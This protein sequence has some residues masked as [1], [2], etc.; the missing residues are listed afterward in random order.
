MSDF[1]IFSLI[2]GPL[3]LGVLAF[4][5]PGRLRGPAVLLGGLAIIAGGVATALTFMRGGGVDFDVTLGHHGELLAAALE[6]GV[7]L[8]VIG[9][10][11]RIRSGKV[12]AL[13]A[14]QLGLAVVEHL[15]P[16]KVASPAASFHI[17]ALAMILIVITCVIGAIIV[18]YAIGY[19]KV[20]EHHAP[21]SARRTGTFFLFLVGFLGAMNGLVMANEFRWLSVFWEAT[22]LCSFMLIGHDGTR[23]ARRNAHRALLI[24]TF[25]GAVLMGGA[26]LAGLAGNVNALSG[27]T[28]GTGGAAVALVCLAMF[29]VAACTK[30]AQMP[31]Q[32]WLLG[33]MVAPTPVSAL[34]HSATMVNAG[35]YI[36]LR[37]CPSFAGSPM[38]TIIALAGAFTFALTSALAAT[39]SN[40]KKVLAYSTIA[41][42]GLIVTCAG[43]N[44]PLAYAAGLMVLCFH[45]ASKGLL[46]LCIGSIEQEIGS[47]DIE[48]M[49]GVLFQMPFT[50]T[51]ALV[52][53]VSMLVPPF[54]MLLCK[55]IAIEAA[56]DSLLV[57]LLLI[58]GSA[59]T[60]VFWA[61]WIGRITTVSYHPKYEM[62]NLHGS[63]AWTKLALGILVIV[64]GLAAV[65]IYVL[66]VEPVTRGV[67]RIVHVPKAAWDAMESAGSFLTWPFLIFAGVLVPIALL[68]TVLRL[69]PQH[70]RPP[71]LC[72]E[73][74]QD[75][76]KSYEF[77]GEMDR[78]TEAWLPSFYF[79]A[80]FDE[81]KVTVWANLVAAVLL[82]SMFGVIRNLH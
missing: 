14:V 26:L 73:N 60:V 50:T 27:L 62:E 63:Q 10:A 15:L 81:S 66:L 58:V 59:L 29:T 20:H 7:I 49:G 54:G 74:V 16:I 67:F 12:L 33:A 51:L 24:N 17:D 46:F 2:L 71:F 82:A 68:L 32:S 45:A 21:A 37:L 76:A 77:H 25:G 30:S 57:L 55:W 18:L 1:A 52:G 47:R 42:L 23:E 75:A 53:M 69:K 44:T 38:L 34:L 5:L 35:V 4:V 19:M 65:P 6:A 79:R 22:T 8:A 43:I 31:F 64:T 72:G 48:D 3:A 80:V 28:A 61:K 78:V 41:N 11:V 39:Q 13:A 9:I 40:G 36:I 70:I 56:V